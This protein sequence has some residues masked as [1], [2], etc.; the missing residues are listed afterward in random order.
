MSALY[1][2]HQALLGRGEA[3]LIGETWSLLDLGEAIG[4]RRGMCVVHCAAA[5]LDVP[6]KVLMKSLQGCATDPVAV[7]GPVSDWVS[8]EELLLRRAAH[9]LREDG[10]KDLLLLTV[11]TAPE[12]RFL[13]YV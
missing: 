7:L 3:H 10:P 11:L 5:S 1:A 12:M 2:D 9:S 13:K 4:P 8:P 6:P